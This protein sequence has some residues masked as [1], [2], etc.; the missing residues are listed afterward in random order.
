[1]QKQSMPRW[2]EFLKTQL[3][4]KYTPSGEHRAQKQRGNQNGK[5]KG[6]TKT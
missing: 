3:G 2:T 4:K 1:M 6:Q 5:K